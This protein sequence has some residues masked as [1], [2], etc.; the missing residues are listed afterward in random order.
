LNEIEPLIFE[1]IDQQRILQGIGFEHQY[2]NNIMHKQC[3]EK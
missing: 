1:R 2:T 3:H